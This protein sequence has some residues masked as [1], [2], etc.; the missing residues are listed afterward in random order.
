MTKTCIECNEDK[1][2]ERYDLNGSGISFRK[3]CKTCNKKKKKK[4]YN[5]VKET[6]IFKDRTRDY[7]FKLRY[8][9]TLEDYNNLL[10]EHNFQCY[11]CFKPHREDKK[12]HVDHCHK[13]N[14][15]RGLLC[16]KCNSALGLLNDSIDNLLQAIKY[17]SK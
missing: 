5:K 7:K 2:L 4:N 1:P 8:G 3:R 6:I 12:L 17:L 13:T 11:I 14:Q 15:V 16:S 9:I 10:I